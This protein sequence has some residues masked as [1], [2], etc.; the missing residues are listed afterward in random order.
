MEE[1]DA[2]RT[3]GEVKEGGWAIDVVGAL[4]TALVLLALAL[5]ILWLP[6][7][8]AWKSRQPRA[9]REGD[10]ELR[11]V[12]GRLESWRYARKRYPTDFTEMNFEPDRGNRLVYLYTGGAIQ[13][14]TTETLEQGQWGIIGADQFKRPKVDT[15][16]LLAKLPA[17]LRSG[18]SPGIEARGAVVVAIGDVDQDG[19]PFIMSVASFDRP[20][21]KAGIPLIEQKD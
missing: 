6:N 7:Y 3:V 1:D 11:I 4:V 17:V 18:V 2:V 15:D 9:D 13:R 8:L 20:E 21:A 16:A 14:R 10:A 12:G 5:L 19:E